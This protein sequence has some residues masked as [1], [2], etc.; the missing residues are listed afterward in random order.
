[1]WSRMPAISSLTSRCYALLALCGVPAWSVHSYR[2]RTIPSSTWQNG[3]RMGRLLELQSRSQ[4]VAYSRSCLQRSP[5]RMSCPRCTRSRAGTTI[6]SVSATTRKE[7]KRSLPGSPRRVTS[8]STIRRTSCRRLIKDSSCQSLRQSSRMRPDGTTK[9]RLIVDMRRSGL[10]AFVDLNE[11]I[12]L[13][14]MRNVVKDLMSLAAQESSSEDEIEWAGVDFAD[15]YQTIGVHPEERKHQVIAGIN[16]QY[17][18]MSSVAFG[19]AGSPLIWGRDAAFLGR[20]GQAFFLPTEARLEV[21]VDDPFIALRGS[22]RATHFVAQDP[23]ALVAV[24]RARPL[25]GQSST[26]LQC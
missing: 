21:Y 4:V 24:S 22:R 1:M 12:L 11:R 2:R 18:V 25:V 5:L 26:R 17:Y 23:D 20:S 14:R 9:I 16:G 3:C 7:F 13:P 6:T 15:A 8:S 10:N 19:G